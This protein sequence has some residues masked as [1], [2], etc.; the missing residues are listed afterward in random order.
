MVTPEASN[1]TVLSNGYLNVFIGY[2][3][4]GGH[5]PPNSTVGDKALWK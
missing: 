3:P 2:I 4:I 1:N 5:W